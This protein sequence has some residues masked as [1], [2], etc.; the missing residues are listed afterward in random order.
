MN[1]L[2]Y[3]SI[4]PQIYF[5]MILFVNIVLFSSPPIGSATGFGYKLFKNSENFGVLLFPSPSNPDLA[6][7]FNSLKFKSVESGKAVFRYGTKTQNG[8]YM[9]PEAVQKKHQIIKFIIIQILSA[10][11]FM[12]GI[13]DPEW[14]LTLPSPRY[15]LEEIQKNIPKTLQ[16]FRGE[17]PMEE[18]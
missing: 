9:M 3:I 4:K 12:I 1:R 5:G 14:G 17:P 8:T 18:T 2:K 7:Y 15:T 16:I 11:E 10:H 13:Y 6:M